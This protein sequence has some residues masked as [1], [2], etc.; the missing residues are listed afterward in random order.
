MSNLPLLDPGHKY[1][2]ALDDLMDDAAIKLLLKNTYAR[3]R[4]PA[5]GERHSLGMPGYFYDFYRLAARYKDKINP[6]FFDGFLPRAVTYENPIGINL[7]LL[8]VTSFSTPNFNTVKTLKMGVAPSPYIST[9]GN[10]FVNN[11]TVTFGAPIVDS[12]Y[13]QH[14]L[15]LFNKLV[16]KAIIQPG[17]LMTP[18]YYHNTQF[19]PF[20]PRAYGPVLLTQASIAGAQGGNVSFSLSFDGSTAL[21]SYWFMYENLQRVLAKTPT[22]D[23]GLVDT[24]IL[25]GSDAEPYFN[26]YNL[27]EKELFELNYLILGNNEFTT[28]DL[29]RPEKRVVDF[30]LQVSNTYSM[31]FN[32]PMLKSGQAVFDN[33]ID[34]FY[35]QDSAGQRYAILSDRQV[36]GTMTFLAESVESYGFDLGGDYLDDNDETRRLIISIAPHF[37]FPLTNVQFSKGVTTFS[38]D[39]APRVKYNFVA[40]IADNA[41]LSLLGNIG[42]TPTSEFGYTYDINENDLFGAQ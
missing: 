22:R 1:L 25:I 32:L 15:L 41:A 21:T 14:P 6:K 36:T 10:A 34:N 7:A 30:S 39:S 8:P 11:S 16:H 4:R 26:I 37:H 17:I 35:S 5:F 2:F 29:S 42:L 40:R 23:A 9:P 33:Q 38:P 27:F 12:T 18:F 28:Y 20:P 31:G 24:V 3:M 13:S 19:P